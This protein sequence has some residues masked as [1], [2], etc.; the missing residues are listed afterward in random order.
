MTKTLVVSLVLTKT[1][2]NLHVHD[3]STHESITIRDVGTIPSFNL[4]FKFYH[5]AFSKSWK[6]SSYCRAL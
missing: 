4:C 5:N 1:H 3:I 6:G 2:T